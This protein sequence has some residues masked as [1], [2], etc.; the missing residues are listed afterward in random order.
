ML[1][2][3][4]AELE[5]LRARGAGPKCHAVGYGVVR[6]NTADVMRWRSVGAG[7]TS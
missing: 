4:V 6:Y 3:S 7:P 5:V 1:G 2:L